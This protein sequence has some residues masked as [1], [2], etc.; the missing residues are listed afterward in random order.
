MTAGNDTFEVFDQVKFADEVIGNEFSN[1]EVLNIEVIAEA[2][3]AD[4]IDSP[5]DAWE[6]TIVDAADPEEGVNI[7][8]T[9][10]ADSDAGL[11]A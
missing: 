4:N 6:N 8:P 11:D 3:Q 9:T 10:E 7:K 2:I 1:K 5:E